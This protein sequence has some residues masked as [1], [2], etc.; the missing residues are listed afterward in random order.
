MRMLEREGIWAYMVGGGLGIEFPPGSHLQSRHF[1]P[2]VHR[3]NQSRTGHMW[4]RVPPFK[5]IDLSLPFQHWRPEQAV[6][7]RDYIA[8]EEFAEAEIDTDDLLE[9][10]V[11]AEFVAHHHRL[12]QM[13]DIGRATRETIERFPPFLVRDRNSVLKYIP[14]QPGAMDGSLEQMRN[15][16]LDGRYPIDLWNDYRNLPPE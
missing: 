14:T 10:D 4:V 6:F 11:T 8:S 7:V 15:L 12:P 3:Q 1:K 5:V 9:A 16:C 2:I 13:R